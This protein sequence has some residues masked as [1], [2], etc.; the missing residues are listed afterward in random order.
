[1]KIANEIDALLIK[2]GIE[3]KGIMRITIEPGR[4]YATQRSVTA[5]AER[6]TETTHTTTIE[7]GNRL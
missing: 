6:V 4:I 2:L 5:D 7:T 1:M 3:N